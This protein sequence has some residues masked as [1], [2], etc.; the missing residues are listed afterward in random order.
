MAEPGAD[1]PISKEVRKVLAELVGQF[2]L[3]TG[4]GSRE[5]QHRVGGVQPRQRAGTE[6]G[7]MLGPNMHLHWT[8]GSWLRL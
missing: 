7:I 1:S 5:H 2:P 8:C 3:P 4:L 6:S